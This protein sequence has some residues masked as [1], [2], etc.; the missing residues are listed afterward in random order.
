MCNTLAYTIYTKLIHDLHDNKIT[1][2]EEPVEL[3]ERA[4]SLDNV[5]DVFPTVVTEHLVHVPCWHRRGPRQPP[6]KH[7]MGVGVSRTRHDRPRPRARNLVQWR[8]HEVVSYQEPYE[9]E[10]KAQRSWHCK[11][12][13]AGNEDANATGDAKCANHTSAYMRCDRRPRSKPRS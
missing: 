9:V 11:V 7:T 1:Y 4:I 5:I 10:D 13:H 3:R 2:A 8:L 6:R 12:C